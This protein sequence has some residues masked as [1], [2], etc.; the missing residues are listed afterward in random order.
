[1]SG[2]L[3]RFLIWCSRLVGIWLLVLVARLIA[4]CYFLY[5]PRMKESV[6]FY[7]ILFPKHGV[8]SNL[9]YT[10][11]QYQQFTTIHQDRF[12]IRHGQL[13]RF[14][15]DGQDRLTDLLAGGGAILLMS[16]LGNWEMAAHLLR[17]QR[18][19]VR[20]L[21]F[22][23]IKE[24]EGVEQLQKEELQAAGV[25][26]IGTA[27]GGTSPLAAVE[28]I[29]WLEAGGLVSMT[30]DQLW[31]PQQPAI[32]VE[33]LGH[34]AR[35]PAAPFA[36]AMVSGAPVYI[37]F[38]FRT[39]CHCYQFVLSGPIRMERASRGERPWVLAR[40][41]QHYADLLARQVRRYPDQWYHFDRFLEEPLNDQTVPLASRHRHP[42]FARSRQVSRGDL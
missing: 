9:L 26:I 18:R 4:C 8:A 24:K 6:R 23:G 33:F 22:M 30:G 20:I 2:R 16:H 17:Q 42:V 34:R 15:A 37:F 3:Y 11:R 40:A 12:R 21:L 7:G 36:L 25:T 13:P 1:M 19:D 27:R 35:I 39:G 5:W 32:D 28:G 38:S 31:H 41:G 10:F 14:C 29:R